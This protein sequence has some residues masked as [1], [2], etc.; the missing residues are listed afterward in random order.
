MQWTFLNSGARLTALFVVFLLT[1]IFANGQS[2]RYNQV[3]KDSV[4]KQGIRT[5][6]LNKTGSMKSYP[7]I[8]LNQ[9]SV[10]LEFDNMENKIKDYQYTIVHCDPGWKASNISSQSY[11]D[12][13]NT[14]FFEDYQHSFN[15]YHDYVHYSLTIPNS[16]MKPKISGNYI[17]KV[18]EDGNQ[19]NLVLTKRFYVVEDKVNITGKARQATYA[20][21]RDYKHE[22]DFTANYQD[23]KD[24][25]N[26]FDQFE[27]MIK[28][29]GRWDNV[30]RGLK[31]S[32]IEG[33]KLIYD[34]DEENL[35]NAGNEFRPLDM[36]SQNYSGRG[37]RKLILD[38]FYNAH[39]NVDESRSYKSHISYN[40]NNGSRIIVT[41]GTNKPR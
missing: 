36:R 37:V 21:Y 38:S 19:E 9:G 24:V 12:G 25:S 30:I 10:T 13:M 18:F 6:I 27:V 17:L 26:P 5:V 40:D 8:E 35:F 1:S 39:L 33:K 15:T 11:I 41:K 20:R 34:H 3:W 16:T 14:G 32:Y 22:V 7:V 23:L 28:Q 2:D 31:P 29:N 4:Y